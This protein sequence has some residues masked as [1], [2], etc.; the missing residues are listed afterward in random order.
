MGVLSWGGLGAGGWLSKTGGGN[1]VLGVCAVG[2]GG[3]RPLKSAQSVVRGGS[4][5]PPSKRLESQGWGARDVTRGW[6]EG[7]SR[8]EDE[9]GVVRFGRGQESKWDETGGRG[10]LGFKM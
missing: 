7:D 8:G 5:E 3:W 1:E 4:S 6:R 9:I 10:A 2:R